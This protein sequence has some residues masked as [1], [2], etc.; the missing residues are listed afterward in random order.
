MSGYQDNFSRSNNAESAESRNCFPASR[1]AKMLGVKTGA[2][3]AVLTPAEWHHTS[4]RYNAT[5]HYDGDLLLVMAGAIRP[6]AQFFDADPADIDAVNDQLAKLRAWKPPAKNERTWTVCT[7]RWL[8][9]GGTRKRPTA[10]EETAVNCTVTWKGGKMCTI[11]PPTGQPFRKGTATR[12][13]EVRDA[14]GKR[15]VF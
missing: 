15:V 6:G 12:G 8:E 2:I 10:T 9:W 4:S 5:D 3:Q 14:S 1:L 11:T 7:V 13:F